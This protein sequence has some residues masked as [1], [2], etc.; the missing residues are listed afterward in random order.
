MQQHAGAVEHAGEG[1]RR[2]ARQPLRGGDDDGFTARAVRRRRA[3]RPD[4]RRAP[5]HDVRLDRLRAEN[6]NEPRD[7]RFVE[8]AVDGRRPCLALR[9]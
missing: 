9:R 4:A 2:G 7:A 1:A 3:A 5:R 6:G 8:N